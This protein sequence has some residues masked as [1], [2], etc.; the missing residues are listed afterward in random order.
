T[1]RP[2]RRAPVTLT[3]SWAVPGLSA[4]PSPSPSQH[5]HPAWLNRQ[6]HDK[7]RAFPFAQRFGPHLSA[8]SLNQMLHDRQAETGSRRGSRPVDLIKTLEQSRQFVG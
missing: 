2:G 1:C 7:S 4:F 8:V 3:I 5:T 6:Q